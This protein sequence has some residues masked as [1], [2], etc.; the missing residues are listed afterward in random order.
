M[1]TAIHQPHYFP[2]LGYLDKMA[3]ANQFIILDE[4]QLTDRSPMVRNKFLTF[5]GNVEML[6]LSVKKKGYREKKTKDIELF[7]VE[8]IQKH[9]RRFF[10]CN[11]KKAFF[12]EEVMEV[13]CPIFDY[14]YLNLI[15]MQMD[16]VLLLKDLFAI[17]T[18]IFYQSQLQYDRESKKSGLIQAICAA[19]GTDIYLSGNGAR[20]YMDVPEF[21]K[22]GIRV[23]YQDFTY[24]VYQ[25]FGLNEFVPN[26]S[27][28][29]I[30]FHLGLDDAR[31]FFWENVRKG[32]EFEK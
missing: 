24:P 16:T 20:K 13:I 26:L 21:E 2:W 30:L 10:E 15:D 8:N 14:P 12:F 31:Y 22:A 11:Y 23:V 19:T 25:Q 3:K 5:S 7:D 9:H 17:E 18:E 4:V 28:L 32:K 1:I 6:S 27:A 29:D